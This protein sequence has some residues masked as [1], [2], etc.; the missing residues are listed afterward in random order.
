MTGKADS[1]EQFNGDIL[2]SKAD[3]LRASDIIP[4]SNKESHQITTAQTE[5]PKFDLAEKIMAEHRKITAVKR[6][7]PTQRNK[8]QKLH[9]QA[10][11][12][13]D[14][15]QQDSVIAEIVARDIARFC[16]NNSTAG[17]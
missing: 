8:P 12:I 11:L 3:V 14:V 17:G 16:R 7:S 6:K 2:P 13:P 4:H 1:N 15:S 10:R 5:M 9:Q